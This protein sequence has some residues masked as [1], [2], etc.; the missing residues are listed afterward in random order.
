VRQAIP[1]DPTFHRRE[2][3]KDCAKDE[4]R[5]PSH[6]RVERNGSVL[7]D[8]L[9][10]R[11]EPTDSAIFRVNCRFGGLGRGTFPEMILYLL[12]HAARQRRIER[13]VAR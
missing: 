9:L 8:N 11:T 7:H 10:R 6:T 12:A 13:K 5:C 2:G 4:K 1:N 3:G